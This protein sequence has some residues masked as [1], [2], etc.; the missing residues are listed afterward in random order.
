[1]MNFV[2]KQKLKSRDLAMQFA[3]IRTTPAFSQKV[4]EV[5]IVN[6]FCLLQH[7][8]SRLLQTIAGV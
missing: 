4:K 1:M 7:I 2:P 8:P 3:A 6:I 5:V